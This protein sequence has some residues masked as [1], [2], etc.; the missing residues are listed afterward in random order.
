VTTGTG[1]L[2]PLS[3]Q[4]GKHMLILSLTGFDPTRTPHVH[5]S[6]PMHRYRSAPALGLDVTSLSRRR[7]RGHDV[8]ILTALI[9][10]VGRCRGVEPRSKISIVIMRPPQ[11]GQGCEAVAKSLGP[12]FAKAYP[13]AT[14]VQ[15]AQIQLQLS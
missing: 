4:T 1:Q 3:G 12:S 5:R 8:S 2:R 14:E 6:I 10:P 9:G 15:R 7:D 13:R 11:H